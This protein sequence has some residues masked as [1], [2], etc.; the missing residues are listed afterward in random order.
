MDMV[1]NY[2]SRCGRRIKTNERNPILSLSLESTKK[3]IC[4]DCDPLSKWIPLY[5]HEVVG[6]REDGLLFKRA[7]GEWAIT[8][9]MRG[10]KPRLPNLVIERSGIPA[11]VLSYSEL[12]MLYQKKSSLSF[13]T[14]IPHKIREHVLI[15]IADV[16]K[17][18]RSGISANTRRDV[19]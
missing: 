18:F 14:G 19:S 11:I 10:V 8:G 15:A 3:A 9:L 17:A 12:V 5:S 13:Y 1:Y 6:T 4:S 16:L 2:C 7:I